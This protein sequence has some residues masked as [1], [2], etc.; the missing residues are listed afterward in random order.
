MDLS[1]AKPIVTP[2]PAAPKGGDQDLSAAPVADPQAAVTP[3]AAPDAV[4]DPQ[5]PATPPAAPEVPDELN[6]DGVSDVPVVETPSTFAETGNKKIDA[7][8]QL[9]AD[10]GVSDVDAVLAEAI[11]TGDLSLEKKADI[12]DKLGDTMADVVLSQLDTEVNTIRDTAKTERNRLMEYAAEAFGDPVES[13][14]EVWAAVQEFAKSE[15]SGLSAEDRKA[16]SA[17][18][19][20]GGMQ[21]ELVIDKLKTLYY[22]D[23]N[24]TQEADLLIGDSTVQSSFEA[25]S[26]KDYA[27]KMREVARDYGYDSP[28]ADK[29]RAQRN[30]SIQR[31]Y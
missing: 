16:M 14:A 5:T 20:K 22:A 13:A 24:Y 2:A 28:Q 19:N 25:I 29:L 6:L 18:L 26:Q 31:G 8:G 9:L 3:Q 15:R 4:T 30:E 10:K 27:N 7:V 1:Q 23:D 11:K 12:I 21:A 17:M